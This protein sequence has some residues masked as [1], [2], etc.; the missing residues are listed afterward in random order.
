MTLTNETGIMVI[1]DKELIDRMDG[2]L[3]SHMLPGGKTL[4]P[5]QRMALA[6]LAVTL[7]LSPFLKE[8]HYIPGVGPEVGIKG[9]RKNADNYARE[10]AED[11]WW[12]MSYYSVN[13]E[14]H[15][16]DH[17]DLAMMGRLDSSMDLAIWKAGVVAVRGAVGD[18]A[19]GRELYDDM[20]MPKPYF[21]RV[22]IV[23]AG[24]IAEYEKLP[25]KSKANRMR[26]MAR[27]ELRAERACL[28]HRFPFRADVGIAPDHDYDPDVV[29]VEV[30]EVK[31]IRQDLPYFH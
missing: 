18:H 1:P 11:G 25:S 20:K 12:R 21:E 5:P 30:V 3:I 10:S 15:G 9:E 7:G 28:R 29:D 6:I 2:M 16:G 26:P 27:A 22:G 31:A 23:R 14:D 19:W 17:G 24:E 4:Q 8:L 13:P